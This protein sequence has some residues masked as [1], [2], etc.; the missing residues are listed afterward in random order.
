MAKVVMYS[1][2]W[3]PFCIRA[4]SLLKSKGVEFENIDVALK[5]G[6]REEMVQLSGRTSVPQIWINNQHIGGCQELYTLEREGV[7]DGL[8]GIANT[9]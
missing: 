4:K 7:L 5:P 9:E 8:L 6:L 2:P 1:T 3:C